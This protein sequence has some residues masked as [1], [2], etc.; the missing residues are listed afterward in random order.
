MGGALGG[1]KKRKKK[2][3]KKKKK[4]TDAVAITKEGGK[5]NMAFLRLKMRI[6]QSAGE[7]DKMGGNTLGR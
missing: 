5:G 2:K 1:P 3:K 6:A 7:T 4:K